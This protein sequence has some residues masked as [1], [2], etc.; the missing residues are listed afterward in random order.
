MPSFYTTP[1]DVAGALVFNRFKDLV[2]RIQI[3]LTDHAFWL[4][5]NSVDYF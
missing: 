1:N 4:G 3:D 2:T 5:I